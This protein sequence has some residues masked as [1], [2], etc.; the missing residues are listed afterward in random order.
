[1]KYQLVTKVKQYFPQFLIISI[2]ILIVFWIFIFLDRPYLMNGDQQLEYNIFYEEWIRLLN[3]FIKTGQLPFYSWYKFLGSDF[4]SSANIFVTSDIFI[5][6]V[7][8][9]DD[10][11]TGLM[12][13]TI[14]LIYISCFAFRYFLTSYG[15]KNEW[16]KT[17]VSILYAFSGLAVLYFGNYMFHRFYAFLPLLYAGVELYLQRNK[18]LLFTI[19]VAILM[20]SSIYF[21]YP[22]SLFMI[23]YFIFAY[24]RLGKESNIIKFFQ[25]AFKLVLYYILGFFL[26]SFMSIPSILTLLNNTR[27]GAPYDPFL[28]WDL[29]V[30]IGFIIS[31]IAAPFALFTNIPY[32]FAS[33]F[34]GHSTWYSV[35][36][37]SLSL[38]VF[39]YYF[40]FIKDKNK[41]HFLFLYL[42]TLVILFFK[43]LNSVFHGFSEPTFRFVFLYIIVTLLITA[44]TLEHYKQLF[45]KKSFLFYFVIILL[46]L[47]GLA[48]L[49]LL[50]FQTYTLHYIFIGFSLLFGL[51]TVLLFKT[52]YLSVFIIAELIINSSLIVYTLNKPFYDYRP[53]ITK[54]YLDYQTEIDEDLYYRTYINPSHLLP[55]NDFNLNQGIHYQYHST[56]TYDTNYEG[57]LHDFL[58]LNGFD[59]HI[60]H[61][62]DPE[63]LSLL[64][65]KYYIVFDESELPLGFNLSHAYDLDFLK[66][67]K[68]NN[69]KGFAYTFNA[70]RD[71]ESIQVTS[72]VD[73]VNELLIYTEDQHR[74]EHIPFTNNR[75]YLEISSK[76]NNSLTGSI[77][78]LEDTI[79]FMGIP[80]N[81]GWKLLVNG[82][83]SDYFKVHGGFMG[84]PLNK[85]FN[86]IE[87][88]FTPKGIKLGIILSL[89]S[90][91][92]LVLINIFKMKKKMPL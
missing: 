70:L 48:K 17:L 73:W 4:Y 11:Q 71:F 45:L 9:F 13:E 2:M 77:E 8:L 47:L 30:T 3:D 56:S 33:G 84:V 34:N 50:D 40:I 78:A 6:L 59:W 65:V 63:L 79:L 18:T 14:L 60:I 26:S 58:H 1:M 80:Y 53:S 68:D 55:T 82:Q 86:T 38:L 35:Y 32:L 28:T 75:S 66:V 41:K 5:P 85:G 92:L 7:M 39:T 52:K 15:L 51:I 88:Y 23:I 25:S 91:M 10:L 12:V 46:S 76:S 57:E 44:Y 29:K 69:F 37:S 27:I 72:E 24:W 83:E 62:Q 36:V 64:G 89:T 42:S 21:M 49:N 87:L 43:P 74:I 90:F 31:H 67:Y 16:N 81:E 22:S 61:I 19:T 54:E 20:I